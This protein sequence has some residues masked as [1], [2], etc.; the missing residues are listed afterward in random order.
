MNKTLR[1]AALLAA[2]L[3]PPAVFSQAQLITNK[4]PGKVWA[5]PA[6]M[7]TTQWG[8]FDNSQPPVLKVDSGDTVIFETMMHA[9]NLVTPGRTIEEI[10]KSRT[11]FPGRGPH[12][13]TGP[14]YIN[15]AEPGD[16]L[17]VTIQ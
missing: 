5:L 15:G 8:W 6:T 3:A 7:E 12:T 13:L 10:K 14:V 2:A 11:D 9:H 17:K 1:G 4:Y 16:V